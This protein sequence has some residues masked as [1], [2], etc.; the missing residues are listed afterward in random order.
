MVNDVEL[1]RLRPAHADRPDLRQRVDAELGGERGQDDG[2]G[3]RRLGAGRGQPDLAVAR[4][5][6]VGRQRGHVAGLGLLGRCVG[7]ADAAGA[8]LFASEHAVQTALQAVQALGGA[9]YTRD[10]PV[11]RYLRNCKAAV[12]YEGTRDIHTLMQADWALGLKKEPKARVS[13][14][15][16]KSAKA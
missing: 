7:R 9:G 14:P 10:Y 5:G 12:I 3:G 13:L 1:A 6:G 4:D 2:S 11:E 8:I 16:Y 15:A